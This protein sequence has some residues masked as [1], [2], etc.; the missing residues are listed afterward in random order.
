MS[1]N[2]PHFIELGNS[3]PHS[4]QS[5]SCSRSNPDKFSPMPPA[6]FFKM[7]LIILP[8][9]PIPLKTKINYFTFKD[10]SYRAVNTYL[11]L[12]KTTQLMLNTEVTVVR[13]KRITELH[14][15]CRTQNFH[16]YVCRYIK[17]PARF[18]GVHFAM[19]LSIFRTNC[20]SIFT[21]EGGEKAK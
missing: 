9:V 19:R 8:S 14:L 3:S 18:K 20:C 7:H 17:L 5:A 1:K 11:S 10:N 13:S 12:I 15:M 6:N 21:S 2:T 16:F 4:Q